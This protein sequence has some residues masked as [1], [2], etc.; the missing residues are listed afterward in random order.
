MITPNPLHCTRTLPLPPCFHQNHPSL[1]PFIYYIVQILCL[2]E[3]LINL[4]DL[5]RPESS[6]KL[7][8]GMPLTEKKRSIIMMIIKMEFG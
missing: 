5:T 2:E 7:I 3:E 6:N 1:G 4:E 8:F